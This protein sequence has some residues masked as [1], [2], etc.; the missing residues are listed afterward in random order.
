MEVLPGK[1]GIQDG[2]SNK[3]EKRGSLLTVEEWEEHVSRLSLLNSH[4]FP[5]T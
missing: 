5:I 4:E 1:R 3:D 2:I